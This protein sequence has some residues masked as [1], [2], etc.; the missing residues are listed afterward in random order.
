MNKTKIIISGERQK[1]MQN[2]VSVV[3]ALVIIQYRY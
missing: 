2:V 1:V 3:E